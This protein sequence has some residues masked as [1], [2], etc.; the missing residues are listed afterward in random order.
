M[1]II[2]KI[3][4][5]YKPSYKPF[6]RL[7]VLLLPHLVLVA[8]ASVLVVNVSLHLNALMQI[9]VLLV[10]LMLLP[11]VAE[12]IL[13]SVLPYPVNQITVTRRRDVKLLL[14]YVKPMK[15]APIGIV[16]PLPRS[17]HKRKK[18]DNELPV[19]CKDVV[20]NECENA[21]DC[22][23][24]NDP[25]KLYVCYKESP[26][27]PA[28]CQVSQRICPSSDNCTTRFCQPGVGCVE[29]NK[30]CN[31]GDNCTAD[32]C[33]GQVLGGCVYTSVA[34]NCPIP[35]DP[36]K[37]SLCHR[38]RGC[39]EV[40]VNCSEQGY[41]ASVANCTVPACNRTCY[42]LFVCTIP[43]PNGVENFPTT[44][45]LA[46]ALGTAA[47][48]GIVIGAAVLVVG[49]GGAAGVAIAGAAGAGGVAL[50]AQN[51]IYAPS[52]A[53]GTNALFKDQS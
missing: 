24:T 43:P 35:G 21:T 13:L 12:L 9:N 29:K 7:P 16:I 47:I 38:E 53:S 32:T 28:I 5:N 46:S 44:V 6:L 49:L 50:V 2:L 19:S 26:L 37:K 18:P 23:I 15:P 25:C 36:C 31:D 39:I 51:P 52:G 11:N 41:Y 27:I 40:P 17:A 22:V 33:D 42:N 20:V 10:L 8:A 4:I 30:I 1:Y 45:V 34:K 14:I 3:G 48:I